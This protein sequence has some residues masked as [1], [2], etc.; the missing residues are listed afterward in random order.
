MFFSNTFHAIGQYDCEGQY[1]INHVFI[2]DKLT[3]P[4]HENNNDI[5]ASHHGTTNTYTLMHKGKKNFYGSNDSWC[6]C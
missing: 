1:M 6:N 4:L 3:Y 5:D 2:C